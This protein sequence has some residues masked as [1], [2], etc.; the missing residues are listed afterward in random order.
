MI[1]TC[2]SA[3][4]FILVFLLFAV[5]LSSEA[6]QTDYKFKPNEGVGGAD[7]L[8]ACYSN[9]QRDQ[10]CRN[11]IELNDFSIR[12]INELI[13]QSGLLKHEKWLG[14]LLG[15]LVNEKLT[16]GYALKSHKLDLTYNTRTQ[17]VSFNIMREF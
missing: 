10:T 16:F 11:I 1:I 4:V 17:V 8:M 2:R 13:R 12:F 5:D 3:I 14:P 9:P 15:V 6:A 7:L